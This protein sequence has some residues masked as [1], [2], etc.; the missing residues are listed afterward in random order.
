[1]SR[2]D[3]ANHR[4]PQND[5][6]IKSEAAFDDMEESGDQPKLFW[7]TYKYSDSGRDEIVEEDSEE[8]PGIEQI[9][10]SFSAVDYYQKKRNYVVNLERGGEFWQA[11]LLSE[12]VYIVDKWFSDREFRQ[13]LLMLGNKEEIKLKKLYILCQNE[14]RKVKLLYETRDE[15][16]DGKAIPVDIIICKIDI[17]KGAFFEIHDR[18]ALLDKEIWHFGGTVGGV[19][20]HLTAYSRGWKDRNKL[21][22]QYLNEI[23]GKRISD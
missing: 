9:K 20:C 6:L 4:K 14:Y 18:F 23:V 8:F 21:F 15:I 11:L 19:N 12:E 16:V 2:R 22:K 1:M 7:P 13:I 17:G 10:E 5:F 3:R